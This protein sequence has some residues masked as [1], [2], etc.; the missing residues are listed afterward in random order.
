MN[1]VSEPVEFLPLFSQVGTRRYMA[2]EILNGTAKIDSFTSLRAAD[3]Y[4]SSFIIWEM[5]Q[6]VTV[7][8][9]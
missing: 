9:E 7:D 2:P 1:N 8:S 4:S 5:A 3:M 6:R